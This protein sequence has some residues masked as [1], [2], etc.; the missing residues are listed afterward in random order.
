M[1]DFTASHDKIYGLFH[2]RLSILTKHATVY[3][4]AKK[5]KSMLFMLLN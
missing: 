1:L 5:K 4:I 2:A 3:K